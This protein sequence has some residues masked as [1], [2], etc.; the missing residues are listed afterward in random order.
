MNSPESTRFVLFT[1]SHFAIGESLREAATKIR[2]A[3]AKRSDKVVGT[4]IL[5][6]LSVTVD[7][8]GYI[9]YGGKTSPNAMLVSLGVLGTVGGL[10]PVHA[11]VR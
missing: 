5:N 3:G 6:D 8:Y 2:K 11:E 9:S 10:I 1:A 7:S 4:L